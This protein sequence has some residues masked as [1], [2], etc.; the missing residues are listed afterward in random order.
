MSVFSEDMLQELGLNQTESQVYAA[1]AT[2]YFRTVEEVQA[3]SKLKT[4]NSNTSTP[5]FP[6]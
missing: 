2:N 4:D 3:Y 6:K 5:S 1:L